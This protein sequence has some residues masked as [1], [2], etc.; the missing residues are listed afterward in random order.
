DFGIAKLLDIERFSRAPPETR[1]G[2]RPMTPRYASPEQIRGDRITTGSDVYT[3]GVILY[4]LLAGCSPYTW[5]RRDF[6][7]LSAAILE[8]NPP[9]PSEAGSRRRDRD[10][11]EIR[12]DLDA[13]VLM[14]LSKEPEYRYGTAAELADELGRY[15]RAE[16]VQARRQ[17]LRYRASRLVQRHRLAIGVASAFLVLLVTFSAA[18]TV[19]ASR[20][21][22]ERNATVQER[23]KAQE[24]VTFLRTLFTEANPTEAG[25]TGITAQELLDRGVR[26][27]ETE[28]ADQPLLQ[29]EL[30]RI[31]GD[32]YY[33][34][35]RYELADELY[36]SS[37]VQLRRQL[38]AGDPRIAETLSAR[39]APAIR[40]QDYRG[41]ERM[42]RQAIGIFEQAD[43]RGLGLA[44]ATQNLAEAV[45]L[46][47]DAVEAEKL[48]RQAL[49]L[50]RASVG[51]DHAAYARTL[52][53]LGVLLD[54]QEEH[55]EAKQL[56]EQSLEAS[57]RIFGDRH[58]DVARAFHNLAVTHRKLGDLERSLALYERALTLRRELLGEEHPEVAL[59]LQNLATL[60]E[61]A[62]RP[63]R[64]E[65]AFREALDLRIRRLGPD[66]P[67]VAESQRYLAT[68]LRNQGR[69][70]EAE[71]AYRSALEI[72]VRHLGPE[73]RV[74]SAARIGLGSALA[75]DG[76]FEEAEPLLREGLEGL[77][78]SMP[79]GHWSLDWAGAL[80]GRALAGLGRFEEA[81]PLL[82]RGLE[83]L[84]ASA[85]APEANELRIL[86]WIA[87]LY[88][89]WGRPERA[90]PYHE[91]LRRR[92]GEFEET[93][94][95]G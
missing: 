7:A 59:T 86:T 80:R 73:A 83:R 31:M 20:L 52:S 19:Q 61:H 72:Y 58:P 26:R 94:A 77:R 67:E 37:L 4:E 65:L 10:D 5:P 21:A 35:G 23:E 24:V 39:S 57:R 88:G 79:A 14:A 41:A 49:D 62:G 15:L 32:S 70:H 85:A 27:I 64:A 40:L 48:Y 75:F 55:R 25:R 66:H 9:A 87:E 45:E 3:L 47:G 51:I 11:G 22:R 33:G 13:I 63:D 95:A 71:R 16:P 44:I 2:V 18:M 81:E 53:N 43:E 36:S 92:R 17:T 34:L 60:H 74:V 76:A 50:L 8:Q 12:G 93:A 42:L 68:L 29:A 91:E 56:F 54:N 46:Q 89:S 84:E 1:T 6:E 30:R 38:P 69:Y 90:E 28:V 82:I 78:A